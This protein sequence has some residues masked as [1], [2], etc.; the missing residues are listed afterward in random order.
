MKSAVALVITLGYC[1]LIAN[2]RY[3]VATF[4]CEECNSVQ[5]T[6]DMNG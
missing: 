4:S 5:S 2:N 3:F 1:F 6:V